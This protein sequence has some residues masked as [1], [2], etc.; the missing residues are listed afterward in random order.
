MEL[1]SSAWGEFE[2]VMKGVEIALRDAW[3]R[4]SGASPS[5]SIS[6]ACVRVSRYCTH[7]HSRGHMRG[8]VCLHTCEQLVLQ[9]EYVPK[10]TALHR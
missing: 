8:S 5:H 6:W 3:R 9:Q 1:A 7:S 2:R 10:W 4:M